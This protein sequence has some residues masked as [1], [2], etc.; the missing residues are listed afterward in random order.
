MS[1]DKFASLVSRIFVAG[2]F[3][4]LGL[5]AIEFV[6]NLLGY[7][8][9]RQYRPGRL[10]ELAAALTVVVIALLMRQI[11]EELRKKA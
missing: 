8:L 5:A 2:A 6:S 11:R 1:F 9:M 7:T 3:L 10:I 4:L